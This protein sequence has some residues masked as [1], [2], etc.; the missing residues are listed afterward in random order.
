MYVCMYVSVA[1]LAQAILLLD[2]SL[3]V[4]VS[5]IWFERAAFFR[6]AFLVSKPVRSLDTHYLRLT[7]KSMAWTKG[8]GKGKGATANP[9]NSLCMQV[10]SSLMP[11]FSVASPQQF[12]DSSGAGWKTVNW[13]KH[14][15]K[16]KGQGN[17]SE[18]RWQGQGRR[19]ASTRRSLPER[20]G[21]QPCKAL[22]AMVGA[23]AIAPRTPRVSIATRV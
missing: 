10:A 5:L 4:Q 15:S 21:C 8:S 17:K 20:G 13:K 23:N 2:G 3:V 14:G 1:I 22:G 19:H 18:H 6:L 9:F 11:L 7:I 12:G 16:S